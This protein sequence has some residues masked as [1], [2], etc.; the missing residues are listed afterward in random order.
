MTLN[1]YDYILSYSFFSLNI[2]GVMCRFAFTLQQNKYVLN[3]L[4]GLLCLFSSAFLTFCREYLLEYIII[5]IGVQC[6]QSFTLRINDEVK[7]CCSM[8]VLL[9]VTDL[10][11]KENIKS[12]SF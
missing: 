1:W 5:H 7:L 4:G 6:F 3:L 9:Q 11:P 12:S 8:G 2:K 10:Y